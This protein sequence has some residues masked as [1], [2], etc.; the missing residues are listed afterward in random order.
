MTR[1]EA[2]EWLLTGSSR[3]LVM[4][5]LN[6]TP[7]SFSDGGRYISTDAAVEH[8]LE[9]VSE[10]A[11][12]IDVGGESTRP[13]A[14]PVPADEEMRRVLPVIERL[15]EASS[16]PISVDTYKA[17][18]AR[19]AVRAGACM[20]NDISGLRFE[21]ELARVA[22][23]T[24]SF[25]VIMHS[26]HTPATMQENPCYEN[27]V[28][29]VRSFLERQVEFAERQGVPRERMLVD[30]GIGFGKTLEHNL[31]LLRGLPRLAELGQ[32]VLVG[33]SRKSFIGMLLGGASP[34]ERLEGTLASVVLS[35]AG[36][37]RVVRVHDVAPA[38]RAVRVADAIVK[39]IS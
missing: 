32:P 17:V 14:T 38:V 21:P 29:E 9:M 10:G 15:A 18:V 20:I 4:G 13:G 8:A 1:V 23:D 7:D 36:G 6:V 3:T 30:P 11:D 24:G 34:E 5:I 12:I 2:F 39:G 35:I 33:V 31:Q 25:L 26:I 22:A 16:V 27:V 37:A 19:E 28:E